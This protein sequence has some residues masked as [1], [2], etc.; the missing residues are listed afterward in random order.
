[1][2]ESTDCDRMRRRGEDE[3]ES[4]TEERE[5]TE[6]EAKDENVVADLFCDLDILDELCQFPEHSP[7]SPWLNFSPLEMMNKLKA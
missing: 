4:E 3:E 5:R 2:N 1:M 7:P 6:R